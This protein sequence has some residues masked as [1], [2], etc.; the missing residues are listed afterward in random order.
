MVKHPATRAER[1]RIKKLKVNG[2]QKANGRSKV[3]HVREVLKEQEAENELRTAV[4]NDSDG[5][6]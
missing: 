4:G 3:K 6:D 2:L 5:I 1:L